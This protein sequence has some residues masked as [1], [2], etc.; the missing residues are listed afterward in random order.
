MWN[1]EDCIVQI[2]N[3]KPVSIEWSEV[4]IK[5]PQLLRYTGPLLSAKY[6]KLEKQFTKLYLSPDYEQIQQL[7]K[8]VIVLK[9]TA[10][11]IKVFALC[12]EALSLYVH[13]SYEYPPKLFK[14]AWKKASKL[15][16]E[17]GLLLQGR[18]LRHLAFMQYVQSNDDK[19]L[20]YTS[21]AK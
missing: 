15:E 14:S 12:W 16:C 13:E 5:E 21:W 8:L 18:V 9:S 1:C 10:P 20:E 7:S 3:R 4:R 19:A 2:I 11:D 17:N 6:H